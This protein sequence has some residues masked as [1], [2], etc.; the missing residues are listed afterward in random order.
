[1]TTAQF[2]EA[3]LTQRG[4]EGSVFKI[5]SDVAVGMAIFIPCGLTALR[6][7]WSEYRK[8]LALEEVVG[9][10]KVFGNQQTD[11]IVVVCENPRN[12]IPEDEAARR[13][14]ESALG[15]LAKHSRK[16]IAMNGIRLAGQN[17]N[18]RQE[19]TLVKWVTDWC[20][21]QQNTFESVSF[22]DL[23]GGFSFLGAASREGLRRSENN[24]II[25]HLEAVRAI[26]GRKCARCGG[27]MAGCMGCL[28][29][30]LDRGMIPA[31]LDRMLDLMVNMPNDRQEAVSEGRRRHCD[32][33]TKWRKMAEEK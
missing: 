22:V 28:F 23:R 2:K 31:A 19:R 33:E 26:V 9:D 18:F 14:V 25:D 11:Q 17:H 3:V 10:L 5:P 29:D 21:S 13:I 30:S 4:I 16:K 1:M 15:I 24:E 20:G 7:D 12:R 27:G 32:R 8:S 6:A